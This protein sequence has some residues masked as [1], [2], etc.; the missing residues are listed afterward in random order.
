MRQY[1]SAVSAKNNIL[2]PLCL[3]IENDMFKMQISLDRH[4]PIL[5]PTASFTTHLI[6]RYHLPSRYISTGDPDGLHRVSSDVRQA[7]SPLQP[8]H[9]CHP[10]PYGNNLEKRLSRIFPHEN[11]TGFLSI[12]WRIFYGWKK[13]YG[14]IRT[15]GGYQR[16][17]QIFTWAV[18][19]YN[20]CIDNCPLQTLCP[21]GQRA[22]RERV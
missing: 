5:M 8:N 16:H 13:N 21:V 9:L 1:I 19:Q 14:R 7:G 18:I 4:S 17:R 3:F 2:S 6:F 11:L 22:T 10:Q 15:L 20:I 12:L